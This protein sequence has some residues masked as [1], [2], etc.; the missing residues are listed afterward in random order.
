V[1]KITG[2]AKPGKSHITTYSVFRKYPYPLPQ[3]VVLQPEF[4][5][6]QIHFSLNHLHTIPHNDSENMFLEICT[7]VLKSKYGNNP[8]S[9]HIR[10]TFGSDNSCE[11]FWLSL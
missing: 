9:I 5:M 8:E 2:E 7:N 4:K 10:I 3:F 1:G 6:N 11:Y